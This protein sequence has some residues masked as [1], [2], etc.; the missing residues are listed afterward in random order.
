MKPLFVTIGDDDEGS[1]TLMVRLPG[2]Q[3][4]FPWGR[5]TQTQ[6]ETLDQCGV[7]DLT[8]PPEGD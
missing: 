8:D 1:L 2:D 3:D 6:R 4:Y 5:I 7:F